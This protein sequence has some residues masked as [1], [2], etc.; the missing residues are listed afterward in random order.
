MHVI[1]MKSWSRSFYF[2]IRA[3]SEVQ[4][5]LAQISDIH[6]IQVNHQQAKLQLCV[7]ETAIFKH[8][9]H[10]P[11]PIFSHFWYTSILRESLGLSLN[12]I[13]RAFW[14][15]P[16]SRGSTQLSIV[17]HGPC[18]DDNHVVVIIG[19][20]S[21]HAVVHVICA[22]STWMMLSS[23]CRQCLSHE[24]DAWKRW[25]CSTKMG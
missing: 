15:L 16:Y 24:D 2:N 20:F 10:S 23:V 3:V 18:P 14:K 22:A 7:N 17:F 1:W 25:I 5:C 9:Q 6:V 8:T 12:E 19:N 21:K 11:I 13:G 4:I